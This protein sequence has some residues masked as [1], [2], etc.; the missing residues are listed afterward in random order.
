MSSPLWWSSGLFESP[1]WG[2]GTESPVTAPEPIPTSVIQEVPAPAWHGL[3]MTWTSWDGSLFDFTDPTSGVFMVDEDVRGLE[4]HE[5][6]RFTSTSPNVPGSQYNGGRI[7][8]RDCFWPLFMHGD[9]L[10]SIEWLAW[11]RKFMR[12]LHYRKPGL[13]SVAQPDGEI[14]SLECR[15]RILD[16]PNRRDPARFG[17]QKVGVTLV[18]EWP[19]WVGTPVTDSWEVKESPGPFDGPGVLNI[20]PGSSMSSASITN[21]GDEPAWLD[22][23]V[24]GPSASTVI[25]VGDDVITVPALAAGEWRS[26]RT[27][28]YGRV[29]LDQN[30]D[31]VTGTLGDSSRFAPVES[32]E[33]VALNVEMTGA[34]LGAKV[35]VSLTPQYL[36]AY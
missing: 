4:L 20:A 8:E 16:S 36:E 14:R 5:P 12:S 11:R 29:M 32:G 9:G 10:D 3:R 33:D 35:A 15:F 25:G 2:V 22:W 31:D 18:A 24:D 26:L 13:W 21:P 6:E 28:P 7:P 34:S 30:G 1:L 17:R 19:Y 27:H 23:R